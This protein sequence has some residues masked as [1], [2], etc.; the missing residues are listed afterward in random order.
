MDKNEKVYTL[1]KYMQEDIEKLGQPIWNANF[2]FSPTILTQD[3]CEIVHEG[4]EDFT[5]FQTTKG[6]N[7]QE[8]IS[9]VKICIA[10]EYIKRT[11]LS[12]EYGLLQIT[13]EGMDFVDKYEAEQQK[14]TVPSVS[15]GTINGPTQVGN[16]NMQNITINEAIQYLITTIESSNTSASEKQEAKSRLEKFLEHPIISSLISGSLLSLL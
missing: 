3:N 6:W 5:A 12:L 9:T 1:L 15:I 16:D 2:D 7:E 11:S 13:D 14:S 8:I 4:G 10:K